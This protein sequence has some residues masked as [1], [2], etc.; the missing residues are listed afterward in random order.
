LPSR[1]SI[2]SARL[3]AGRPADPVDA[4]DDVGQTAQVIMGTD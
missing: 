3:P 2:G 4:D 1:L